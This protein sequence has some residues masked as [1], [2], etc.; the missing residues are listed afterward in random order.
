[1]GR[2]TPG[3]P[4]AG[5]AAVR[6]GASRRR[7]RRAGIAVRVRY[8][9]VLPP[10]VPDS[11]S[12]RRPTDSVAHRRSRDRRRS[13]RVRHRVGRGFS[14]AAWWTPSGSLDT[15]SSYTGKTVLPEVPAS[16]AVFN[17][18]ARQRKGPGWGPMGSAPRAPALWRTGC[19][20]G[21]S[22]PVHFP[23]FF[24]GDP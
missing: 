7:Y 12:V 4:A 18:N 9:P 5:F 6:P 23:L 2:R 21:S 11:V 17:K 13:E 22:Y 15:G 14:T 3:L 16:A 10:N 8:R 20:I 1:M 19:F 24:S